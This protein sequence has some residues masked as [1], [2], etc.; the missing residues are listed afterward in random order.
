[1]SKKRKYLYVVL[2]KFPFQG[3]EPFFEEEL[4]Y[5]SNE[6]ITVYLIIPEAHRIQNKSISYE[7]PGNVEVAD[8]ETIVDSASRFQAILFLIRLFPV[9]FNRIRTKYKIRPGIFHLRTMFGF[10]SMALKFRHAFSKILKTH[11]HKP[12]EVSI[13]SYWFFYATAGLAM[14]KEKNPIYLVTTRIHGWDCFFERSSGNYLPLRPYVF[15]KVNYVVSISAAGRNY[16]LKKLP[17]FSSK[18]KLSYLGIKD[19]NNQ[20]EGNFIGSNSKLKVVSVAYIDRVKQLERIPSAI[21]KCGSLEID[22]THI[23]SG[24]EPIKSQLEYAAS[25]AK[26]V[27]SNFNYSFKGNLSRSQV[28][29]TLAN[30]NPDVLICTSESE[31]LPVS[32]MEAMAHG[33]PVLSVD[34]G[35][36]SEIVD[37]GINGWLLPAN[38]GD[39]E[40]AA[41]IMEIASLSREELKRIKQA[42]F[43]KYSLRFRA[44]VNYPEFI[45]TMLND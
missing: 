35:G 7:L 19:F 27:N 6:F 34:V 36:I 4:R 37:S 17:E 44:S 32:M 45:N 8:F 23:G 25:Q 13:Y 43:E 16:I 38:A 2:T 40:I 14:I 5:L 26:K 18:I 15:S 20:T 39:N 3:G 12:E 31:G 10:L 9:E 29:E 21:A 28:Y 24:P 1:M 33:I 22:W 11:N 30:E 41:K 42:A